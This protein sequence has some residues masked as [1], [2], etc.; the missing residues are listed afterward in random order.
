VALRLAEAAIPCTMTNFYAKATNE[1][2]HN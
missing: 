1:S 2:R